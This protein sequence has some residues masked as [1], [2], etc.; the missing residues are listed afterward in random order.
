MPYVRRIYRRP[1]VR[2]LSRRVARMRMSTPRRRV[3]RVRRG[4]R[5]RYVR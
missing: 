5:R 3:N 4:Y 1:S 2:S